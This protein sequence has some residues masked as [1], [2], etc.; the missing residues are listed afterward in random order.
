MS[1][2]AQFKVQLWV[3]P[4]PKLCE[5]DNQYA[6]R[7]PTSDPDLNAAVKQHFTQYSATNI[8]YPLDTEWQELQGSSYLAI[9]SPNSEI[10]GSRFQSIFPGKVMNGD[11]TFEYVL[12]NA[13]PDTWMAGDLA[14]PAPYQIYEVV[15]VFK[16]MWSGAAGQ[17][18]QINLH[19]INPKHYRN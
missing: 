7:Y 5:Q 14:L 13:S 17:W 3:T 19:A 11:F 15:P 4:D 6:I 9:M 18:K 1:L 12:R 10:G 2:L 16:Y 8:L